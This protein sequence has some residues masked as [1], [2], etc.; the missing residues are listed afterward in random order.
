MYLSTNLN[1]LQWFLF[2][3]CIY[4]W[5]KRTRRFMVKVFPSGM[6]ARYTT[7]IIV[8]Y[9][10]Q[11]LKKY[12][13]VILFRCSARLLVVF[14][15][16]NKGSWIPFIDLLLASN[17][18]HCCCFGIEGVLCADFSVSFNGVTLKLWLLAT[19]PSNKILCFVC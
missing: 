7:G 18:L 16:P 15:L 19:L 5:Y 4:Y 1:Y 14:L 9:W 12:I 13:S 17:L 11:I 6:F 10:I 3:G 8:F 2:N